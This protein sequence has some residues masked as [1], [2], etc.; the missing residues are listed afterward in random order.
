[1]NLTD[2][3]ALIGA[4]LVASCCVILI[5]N[6]HYDDGFFGRLGLCCIALV[7]CSR[8]FSVLLN[9][10]QTTP[11]MGILLWLG[12]ALFLIRHTARFLKRL[13]HRDHTW[14]RGNGHYR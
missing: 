6:T 9:I 1:M 10:G 12:L 7:A 2:L 4:A 3:F 8:V 5:F 13:K 11:P 14:Y